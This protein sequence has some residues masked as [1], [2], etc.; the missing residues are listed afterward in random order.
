MEIMS[1]SVISMSD[2]YLFAKVAV[3]I[4]IKNRF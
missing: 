4:N 2:F 1:Q 3:P